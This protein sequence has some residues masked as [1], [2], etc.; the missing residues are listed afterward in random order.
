MYD[1]KEK[2]VL[3]TGGAAGIGAGVVEAILKEGAKHIAALDV[4]S[5]N[6]KILEDELNNNYKGNK[7]KFYKCDVTSNDLETVYDNVI[8]EHKYIDVV[9]NCAGIMNDRPNVYL[10]E[11]AVNVTALITSSFK[12]YNLMRKDHGGKGGTI[13]NISSIVGLFQASLLPVYASTKSAV[14]QFSTCLGMEPHYSH[15]G[16]RVL[17]LCFGCTD[18]TLFSSN[19]LGAFDKETEMLLEDSIGTLPMQKPDSAVNG[20]LDAYRDGKSG[21]TWLITADKPAEDITENITKGFEIMS[22]GVFC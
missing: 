18:T 13:I 12:A 6:G 10:K 9:V 7:V 8:K 15:S 2:V 3:V 20:L 1:F 19:K 4:D 21:S 16:V 11:I 17:T 14:L 22:R 5:V